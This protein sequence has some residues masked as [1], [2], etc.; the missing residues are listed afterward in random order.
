MSTNVA[1]IFER[2]FAALEDG[3]TEQATASL[4]AAKQAGVAV[5]D[6][7]YLHLQGLIAWA[8]G[9]IDDAATLLEQAV[10]AGPEDARIYLDAGELLADLD[11][12]DAAENVFRRLLDRDDL[13][14]ETAAEAR[15][16]LAQVRLD[17]FDSDP[18]EALELLDEVDASLRDDPGYVSLRAAALLQKGDVDQGIALLEQAIAR[19]DDVELRYQLGL[20]CRAHGREAQGL[21]ALLAVREHDLRE[22]GGDST[23]PIP[24]DEVEDL[25]RR[26]EDVI[27]TLP[28]PILALV[29]STAIRVQRWIDEAH[30]RAG[31]DPRSA[32]AFE[33]KPASKEDAGDGELTGIVVFR[34]VLVDQIDDDDDIADAL[35]L[36]VLE[37]LTRFFKLEN[38][39]LG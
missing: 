25:R 24:A 2:A 38:L 1:A 8:E 31:V 20:A 15:M 18:E 33:G 29:A 13:S 19:E 3:E 4:E 16:L 14:I 27:D 10:D 35:A 39:E 36:G 23:T 11:E 30:V 32:V 22:S 9:E 37:E 7:R 6:P 12:L 28:D 26:T 5:D 21:A 34:D 17:H